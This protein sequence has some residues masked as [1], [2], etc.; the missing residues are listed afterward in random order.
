MAGGKHLVIWPKVRVT[1]GKDKRVVLLAGAIVPDGVSDVDLANLVS[2]GA[3][4]GATGPV[5]DPE[6]E[7]TG[8]GSKPTKVEDILAEVGD[9]KEKAAAALE[10]EVAGKNRSTL[11]KA[12][13]DVL[14]AES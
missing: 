2:F 13:E 4:A 7:S 3:I 9:D 6:P 8:D 11:V 14:N 5:S 1:V 12:L 10:A